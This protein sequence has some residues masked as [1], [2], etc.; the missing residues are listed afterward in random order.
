MTI[1]SAFR[2]YREQE[3]LYEGFIKK[4][5]GFNTAAKP[6]ASKHQNGVAFDIQVAGGAGDPCY[7][8]LTKNAPQRGFVRTVEQGAVA[9]GV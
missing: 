4:L 2:S 5:P 6:G 3:A 1:N 8:W 9:L 7:D